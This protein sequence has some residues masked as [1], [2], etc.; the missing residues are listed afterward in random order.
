MEKSETTA[1]VDKDVNSALRELAQEI[2]DKHGICLKS[3]SFSWIDVSTTVDDRLVVT[4][5][6]AVTI[7]KK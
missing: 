7:T 1:L 5:V 2:W 6:E 3:A 4:D